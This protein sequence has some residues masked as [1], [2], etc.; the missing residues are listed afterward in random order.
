MILEGKIAIVTG[1]GS[2]I[3]KAFSKALVE[4]GVKVYGVG[5]NLSKLTALEQ[6]LGNLFTPMKLDLT[7]H[8]DIEQW[9]AQVFNKKNSPDILI[10]NAGVGHMK[11]VEEL[12][13]AEW[14]AMMLT[15]LSGVFYLTR[16]I[17]PFM[18]LN[19]TTTHIINIASIAGLMGNPLLSGYN[20]T[21]YGLRG[22]S[23][24]LFK[25]LRK[26]HIKVTCMLPG[27]IETPFFDS[28]D[29]ITANPN[30]LQAN[31]VATLLIQLLETPDNFLVSEV[32]LR[33]LIA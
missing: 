23:D 11:P 15:N 31:D 10:N 6:E 32:T 8:K 12:S 9:V 7:K 13:V 25:E 22:F 18:K 26:D 19:T 28:I 24:A 30:M 33:P 20:A 29:T 14:D 16:L 3:G 21:K 27:S 1:A 5:R 4:K 17:V 2:G